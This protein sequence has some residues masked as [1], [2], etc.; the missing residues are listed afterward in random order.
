MALLRR[1]HLRARSSSDGRR[2][3]IGPVFEEAAQVGGEI[4][5]GRVAVAGLFR[6]GLEHDGFQFDGNGRVD[7]R[8][9]R[10]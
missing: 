3:R 7:A 4:L 2:A 1:P 10:G 9:G 8:G 6:Q 5:S